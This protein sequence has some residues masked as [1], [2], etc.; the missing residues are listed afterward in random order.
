MKETR[1]PGENHRPAASHWQTFITKC[2]IVF[3]TWKGF[4]LTTLVVIVS[5]NYHAIATTMAPIITNEILYCRLNIY[6]PQCDRKII[7]ANERLLLQAVCT[8]CPEDVI[9]YDW[10]S[11]FV[12]KSWKFRPTQE[13][14][15]CTIKLVDGSKFNLLR[16]ASDTD[17]GSMYRSDT[18]DE[19]DVKRG[20]NSV[21]H[22]SLFKNCKLI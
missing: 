1:V 11:H 13:K 10:T 5:S 9:E 18:G 12:Y 6:C 4:K 15:L 2:F 21:I 20:N 17:T 19:A 14:I 8:N 16:Q 3:P 22:S 7:N